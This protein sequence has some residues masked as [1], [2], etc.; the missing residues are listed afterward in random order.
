MGTVSDDVIAKDAGVT[1][2]MV[3]A[4]R[5]KHGIV[6]YAGYKWQKGVGP[7]RRGGGARKGFG[8]PASPSRKAS[9]S[10]ASPSGKASGV[11]RGTKT[12]RRRQRRGKSSVLADF[13]ADL[14]KLPD[15][16]IAARAG[17]SRGIVGKF[18]R[19]RGIPAYDG[20]KFQEGHAPLP[21]AGA[22]KRGKRG[23]P[24]RL[25]EFADLIGTV[26]DSEIAVMAGVSR[27]SVATWRHRRGIPPAKVVVAVKATR[28]APPAGSEAPRRR[29][30]PP[31]SKNKPKV[32]LAAPP[33]QGR[34]TK[35]LRAYT[36]AVSRGRERAEYV[37]VGSSLVDAAQR[38]AS[39]LGGGW[40][41]D[42]LKVLGLAL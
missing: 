6:A 19:D 9:V 27:P 29:G 33:S 34:S 35:G 8:S 37:A 12:T 4:Y 41:I 24:G 15:D 30:R 36:V 2:A 31:G 28:T 21:G 13:V 7:P 38:I 16:V 40:S 20:Y 26:P 14:G 3:G 5:R 39:A 17:L 42:E 10:P 25:Q 11:A 22:P 32:P 23:P 1:R 18:R